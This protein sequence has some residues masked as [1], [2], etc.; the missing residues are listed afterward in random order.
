MASHPTNAFQLQLHKL[1]KCQQCAKIYWPDIV[2]LLITAAVN[3]RGIY[4]RNIPWH[5]PDGMMNAM[6]SQ[7]TGVT[8]CSG[9]DQKQ[10]QSSGSVAFVKFPAQRA[11]NA[12]NVSIWWHY[13]GLQTLYSISWKSSKQN[14]RLPVWCIISLYLFFLFHVELLIPI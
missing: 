10:H 1:N 6:A 3:I 13:H 12:E 8:V 11:S 14:I 7:I 2:A 4:I 5:Y 9:E